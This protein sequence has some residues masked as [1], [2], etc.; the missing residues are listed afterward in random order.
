MTNSK[1]TLSDEGSLCS[2]L[3]TGDNVFMPVGPIDKTRSC[4][5]DRLTTAHKLIGYAAV[6]ECVTVIQ[7]TRYEQCVDFRLCGLL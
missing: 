2:C 5:L 4:I 7:S 1:C 3:R 6:I